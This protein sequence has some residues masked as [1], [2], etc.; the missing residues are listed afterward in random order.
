MTDRIG[1]DKSL[2]CPP[3]ATVNAV[4]LATAAEAHLNAIGVPVV[5]TEAN[6]VA[7]LDAATALI[8]AFG[9]TAQSGKTGSRVEPRP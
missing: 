5:I 9:P 4:R 3:R 7:V 8:A 6:A 2:G 1:P